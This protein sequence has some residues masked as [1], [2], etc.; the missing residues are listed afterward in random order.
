MKP[1]LPGSS[2]NGLVNVIMRLEIG[3]VNRKERRNIEM[4][5]IPQIE[6]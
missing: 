6:T 4:K 3:K 1:G 2:L 5:D